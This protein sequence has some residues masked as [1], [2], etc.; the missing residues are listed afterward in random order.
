MLYE[1]SYPLSESTPTCVGNPEEKVCLD[2]D[3]EKGDPCTTRVMHHFVHTGTHVDAPCHMN[4]NGRTITEIPIED[5]YYK[6]PCLVHIPKKHGEVVTEQELKEHEAEIDGCDLICIYTENAVLRE[7][8]PDEYSVNFPS[9]TPEAA[10]YLRFHFPEL[11]AIALDMNS[12]D[13]DHGGADGFPSHHAILDDIDGVRPLLLYEDVNLKKM[14]E[15]TEPIKAVC[16][17]P[18]RWEN[19]EAAPVGMIVICE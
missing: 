19:A 7:A 15:I 11:K 10:K 4:P 9:L 5:F 12:I 8:A 1:I 14:Y 16:A 6:R 17:C 3:M 13:T 18:V 2:L